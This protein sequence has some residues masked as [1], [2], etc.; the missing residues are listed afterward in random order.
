MKRRLAQPA[1]HHHTAWVD[2]AA[3]MTPVTIVRENSIRP[4]SLVSFRGSPSAH[5]DDL[6]YTGFRR[7]S[8][9][10]LSGQPT[11]HLANLSCYRS[12]GKRRHGAKLY[13]PGVEP[14]LRLLDGA[15][16]SSGSFTC[17]CGASSIVT[18]SFSPPADHPTSPLCGAKTAPLCLFQVARHCS[19][20]TTHYSLY[21]LL[22][23]CWR[24]KV[25]GLPL[26]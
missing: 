17:Y 19:P 2:F 11:A 10:R 8:T 13:V 26:R 3:S 9:R 7:K 25:T 12:L 6:Q 5:H 21:L 18:F 15:Q 23:S 24:Y 14:S 20:L 22:T 1:T 4:W 16:A